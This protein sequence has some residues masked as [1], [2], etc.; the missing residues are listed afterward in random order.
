MN[1]PAFPIL[2]SNVGLQK[3]IL[4]RNKKENRIISYV[5]RTFP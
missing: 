5:F 4:V 2:L 1:K 3:N